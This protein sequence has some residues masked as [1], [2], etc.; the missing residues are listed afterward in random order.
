MFFGE[1]NALIFAFLMIFVSLLISSNSFLHLLLLA[2]L[3][4]VT[5]YGLV[6][7]GGHLLNDLNM[8][9]L[10][11][12]FLI[13]SAIELGIGLELLSI[14]NMAARSLSP[15]SAKTLPKYSNKF[16]P[17]IFTTRNR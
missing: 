16:S 17:K 6:L 3:A 14:Q 9:S 8:L 15:L 4:W 11:F 13:F 2:E 1:Y 7:I 5:L 10:T 12:F